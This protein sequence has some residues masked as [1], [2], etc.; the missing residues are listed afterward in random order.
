MR[1]NAGG[2][3][4]PGAI[5]C[6]SSYAKPTTLYELPQ[7]KSYGLTLGYGMACYLIM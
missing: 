2:S 7:A 3:P 1:L 5:L 6:Q 4:T